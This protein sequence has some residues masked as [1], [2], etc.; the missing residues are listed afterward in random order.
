MVVPDDKLLLVLAGLLPPQRHHPLLV[1]DKHDPCLGEL[2]LAALPA[3]S[4][5]LADLVDIL[6]AVTG[7][8]AAL[9]CRRNNIGY[10]VPCSRPRPEII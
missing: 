5:G 4:D 8:V 2:L 9:T 1:A 7:R 6:L 3:V 10:L